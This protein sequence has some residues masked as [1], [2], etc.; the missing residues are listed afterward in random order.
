MH[1][2]LKSNGS[3]YHLNGVTLSD[4]VITATGSSY[5]TNCSRFYLT[6]NGSRYCSG[7]FYSH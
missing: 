3:F 5:D 2:S 6:R 4:Y 1:W 7:W